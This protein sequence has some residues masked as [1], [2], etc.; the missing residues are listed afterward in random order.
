MEWSGGCVVSGWVVG[1]VERV[2]GGWES[3]EVRCAPRAT[4]ATPRASVP[5]ECMHRGWVTRRRP[6][7]RSRRAQGELT[8]AATDLETVLTEAPDWT[9]ALQARTRWA[10]CAGGGR[11]LPLVELLRANGCG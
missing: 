9:D 3:E 1:W 4:P 8:N 6:R 5:G 7:R 10:R 2:R 11:A